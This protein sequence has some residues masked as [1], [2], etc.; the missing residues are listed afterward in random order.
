MKKILYVSLLALFLIACTAQP[1]PTQDVTVSVKATLT[2]IAQQQGQPQVS[3][4]PTLPSTERPQPVSTTAS[5]TLPV[6]SATS[7]EPG[8]S[9]QI[10]HIELQQGAQACTTDAEYII[11]AKLTGVANAAVSYTVSSN[12]NGAPREGATMMLDNNGEAEIHS[13]IRGPFADPGNIQI[14]ITVLVKGQAVNS[15]YAFICQD[16]NYQQ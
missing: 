4:Q 14:T 10:Q 3:E 1:Q 13:G 7:S 9:V 12:N 8:T 5:P 6:P 11:S 15:A 2:A 16:G